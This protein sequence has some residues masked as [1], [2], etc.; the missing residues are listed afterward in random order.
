MNDQATILRGL[1]EK[2][3]TA[4]AT[5]TP[6]PAAVRARTVAVTSGKGGVGKSNVALNLA[7]ALQRSG[8]EVCL[9]DANAGLGSIDLLSGVSGYWNLGH[10]ISGAR[11]LTEICLQGPGNI[12]IIPGA[13]SLVELAD[14]TQQVRQDILNQLREIE[15]SCD[16]IVIDTGTGIQSSV[17]SFVTA[18]DAVLVLTTPE[19]TSIADSYATIKSLSMAAEIPILEAVVNQA[20][21]RD[22]AT[23]I[24]E[25]LH[26][27]ARVFLRIDI[28]KGGY[29]P[30]D[31]SIPQAVNSRSPFLIC[32]PRCPASRAIEQL[33]RRVKNV[34]RLKSS[35]D[36]FFARFR[37]PAK[38][39]AA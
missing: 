17:R 4:A 31:S 9:L 7:I 10:V 36:S 3:P 35:R 2:Q 39:D 12:R 8:S 37:L 13:S 18:A 15:Q 14:C 6:R 38:K 20:R 19:P 5:P 16:F 22:N 27:T 29:I 34:T 1:V 21:D 30:F 33:A 32:S 26:E 23:L 11:T 24:L 25:R 28:G